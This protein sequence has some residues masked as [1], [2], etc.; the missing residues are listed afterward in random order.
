MNYSNVIGQADSKIR[1]QNMVEENRVPHALL[2]KGPEGCGNLP[3]AI[4]FATH[5]LCK[6]KTPQGACGTC[7]SCVQS[8]KLTHPDLHLV[9]PIVLSKDVRN[10]D[11]W[12][13]EFRAAFLKNPYLNLE[14][15]FI[16]ISAEN[17]QPVIGTDEAADIL[18]KL[19]YTSFEGQYKILLMWLPEKM[20]AEAANKILK[21]LE[22]P[23]DN[24]IFILVS[25]QPDQLL[26]TILS[27]VQQVPLVKLRN[28]EIASALQTA[29][30]KTKE[31]AEQMALLADGNFNE[32][33]RMLEEDT[34]G[35]DLTSHFQN[36]MRLA[37][38]FDFA[39]VQAWVEENASLGREKQ[40]RF[41]QYGLEVF[42]DCLM[43]N[44]GN[45]D[46]VRLSGSERSFLEKFAPFVNQK[47]YE[48]LI[49]EFNSNYYYIERN[50]NPKILFMDL[51]IKCNALIAPPK[52][53]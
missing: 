44:Y 18:R 3:L 38:S 37:F 12:V 27:R 17:K 10:S 35:D 11:Y 33:L 53:S 41:F 39:K 22:E 14:D 48:K 29:H 51:F 20:N 26:S 45:R 42:R 40:K 6:Q 19:S 52:R 50:A 25:H 31:E 32:A 46:L 28:E 8:N 21:V 30:G 34:L 1:L 24:T 15:W 4:A 47:N 16:E 5:L 2:F 9:F 7:S 49:E 23:S 43:Y 13:K 36:F